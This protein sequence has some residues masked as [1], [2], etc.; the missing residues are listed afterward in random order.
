M[1]SS[2]L[3]LHGVQEIHYRKPLSWFGGRLKKIYFW[4]LPEAF[5]WHD[6][7]FKQETWQYQH[8]SL[9]FMDGQGVQYYF[10]CERL[11]RNGVQCPS[12]Q[13]QDSYLECGTTNITNYTQ[14]DT[15]QVLHDSDK[16]PGQT[17]FLG[18]GL[19]VTLVGNWCFQVSLGVVTTGWKIHSSAQFAFDQLPDPS[20]TRP[21]GNFEIITAANTVGIGAVSTQK[22]QP[23]RALKSYLDART[24]LQ[25]QHSHGEDSSRAW[26]LWW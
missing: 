23:M 2:K 11:G 12:G 10:L 14:K 17:E 19:K 26:Q 1:K 9:L 3:G 20:D 21:V 18:S 6:I 24:R 22:C 4:H 5:K 16:I 8:T 15:L 7:L 13:L 25:V